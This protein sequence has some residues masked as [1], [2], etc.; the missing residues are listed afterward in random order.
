MP[1]RAHTNETDTSTTD[2]S[3]TDTSAATAKDAAASA[4]EATADT[5][6][7]AAAT[8]GAAGAGAVQALR[9]VIMMPA[10]V[11]REVADDVVTTVR[12]PDAVLYIG[13]LIGLAALGVLEWPVAA[14]AGVGVAVANGVRRART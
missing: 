3:P 7:E 11:A 5:A 10:T 4:V 1:T 8:T 6:E 13:G 14:A 12:R 2:T 9:Q